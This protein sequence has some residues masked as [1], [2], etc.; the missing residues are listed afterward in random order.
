LSREGR[1]ISISYAICVFGE[2]FDRPLDE[3]DIGK[4]PQWPM[5]LGDKWDF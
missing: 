2:P 5:I 4:I 3:R 1:N